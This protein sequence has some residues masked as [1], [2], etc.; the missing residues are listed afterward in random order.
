VSKGGRIERTSDAHQGAVLSVK[1]NYDGTSFATS[2]EDGQIKIWSRS[3]MLRSTLCQHGMHASAVYNVH[4]TTNSVMLFSLDRQLVIQSLQ[5]NWKAHD[6]VIL[7][8]G[9]NTI[10][11]LLISGSEDCK[12]KVWDSF[13]RLLYSSSPFEYP[14]TSLSWSPD[15]QIQKILASH[16]YLMYEWMYNLEKTQTGSIL[17][18]KWSSD[19]TQIA[20]AGGNG[21]IVNGQIIN[22]RTE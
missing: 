16:N 5:A 11:D 22:R 18:I 10:C 6:G 12:Y 9:W 15:G 17:S 13:G 4:F 7:K 3:G 19:G 2:G 1:W 21:R 20:C 14:I 8:V